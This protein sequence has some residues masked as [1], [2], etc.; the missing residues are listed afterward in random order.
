MTAGR[1][2]LY[3]LAALSTV[4]SRSRPGSGG[5]G[6]DVD[7]TAP[8]MATARAATVAV[9]GS[10]I[11]TPRRTRVATTSEITNSSPVVAR[12]T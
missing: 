12:P 9:T 11:H 2:S 7:S 8:V 5:G 6:A 3:G 4:G 1:S 10:A